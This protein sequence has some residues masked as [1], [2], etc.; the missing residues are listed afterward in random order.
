MKTFVDSSHYWLSILMRG[1]SWLDHRHDQHHDGVWNGGGGD[2]VIVVYRDGARPRNKSFSSSSFFSI[3][4]LF[5][6]HSS[7]SSSLHNGWGWSW[8]VLGLNELV[9]FSPE[10]VSRVYTT[11]KDKIINVSSSLSLKVCYGACLHPCPFLLITPSVI[12]TCHQCG[13]VTSFA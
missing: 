9:L 10:K 13:L 8:F 11:K 3:V 4:E 1:R 12:V 2:M 7:S 6:P 5:C